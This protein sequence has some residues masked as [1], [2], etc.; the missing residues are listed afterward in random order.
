MIIN[1]ETKNLTKASKHIE[2]LIDLIKTKYNVANSDVEMLK[3]SWVGKDATLFFQNWQEIDDSDSR[4]DRLI[5]AL[6]TYSSILNFASNEYEAARER[7]LERAAMLSR[8]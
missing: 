5:Q 1:V 3:N 2:T 8:L 7:A 6:S 4:C